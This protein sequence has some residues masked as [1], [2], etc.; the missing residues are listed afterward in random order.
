[1]HAVMAKVLIKV[2]KNNAC[3]IKLKENDSNSML[4]RVGR[5][6]NQVHAS[7][8]LGVANWVDAYLLS[9]LETLDLESWTNYLLT[10]SS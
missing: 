2:V 5:K 7:T 9:I 4:A 1:M 8:K 6:E 3:R 10:K